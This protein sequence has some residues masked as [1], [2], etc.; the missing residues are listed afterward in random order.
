MAGAV[1]EAAGVDAI[2]RCC[3]EFCANR[4]VE[5]KTEPRAPNAHITYYVICGLR[6]HRYKTLRRWFMAAGES[7]RLD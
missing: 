2:E 3:R 4:S 7:T 1:W 5:R 6:T